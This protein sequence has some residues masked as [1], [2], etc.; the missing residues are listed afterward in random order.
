MCQPG[1]H[2]KTPVSKQ[3]IKIIPGVWPQPKGLA[4]WPQEKT[5]HLGACNKFSRTQGH[6]KVLDPAC[7]FPR[8]K[9]RWHHCPPEGRPP[10]SLTGTGTDL[11]CT[12]CWETFHSANGRSPKCQQ[13]SG[14]QP[15][16]RA[17]S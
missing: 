17:V 9:G 13:V 14:Q 10:G 11:P 7:R 16:S 4:I 1:P 3:T 15:A 6:L 8:T 2:G 5:R 12:S